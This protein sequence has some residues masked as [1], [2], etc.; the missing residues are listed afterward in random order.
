MHRHN[1][2]EGGTSNLIQ[3]NVFVY[4]RK[5]TLRI[6]SN[7]KC[8]TVHRYIKIAYILLGKQSMLHSF[9]SVMDIIILQNII[10]LINE[11]NYSL[12]YFSQTLCVIIILHRYKIYS[13]HSVNN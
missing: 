10:L 7:M 2:C 4:I 6:T 13:M 9:F 5:I 3:K 12:H 1:L 8:N 11:F